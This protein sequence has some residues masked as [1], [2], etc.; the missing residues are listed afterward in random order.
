MRF[1]Q[2]LKNNRIEKEDVLKNS[3]N[4]KLLKKWEISQL[5]K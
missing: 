4:A 1:R 2:I 3:I 5:Q